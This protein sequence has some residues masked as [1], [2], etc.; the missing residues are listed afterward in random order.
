MTEGRAP[1]AGARSPLVGR[2]DELSLLAQVC[3]RAIEGRRCQ[4]VTIMGDPG[5]GKTRLAEELVARLG[6]EPQVLRGRCLPYGEGITFYPIAEA[7]NQAA[8]LV[9]GA[10]PEEARLKLEALIGPDPDGITDILAEAIGLS[11]ATP[12][13][14]QTLWAI[15]RFFE[16]L[17]ADR[18]LILLFDDLQWGEPTF[19]DLLDS[20]THRA[21][22]VPIVLLCTA[23]PE[24]LERR[25][26]WGGGAMHALTT[27]LEPLSKH[28]SA[29]MAGNLVG[30]GAL[31]PAIAGQLA[32]AGG[33]NPLF[34]QE[35]VAMLLE[36]GSLL[37]DDGGW[38]LTSDPAA[39]ATPP[40]L[41][42]LLA[43]RLD[44]LP[45]DERSVLLHA[46]VIGKVFSVGEVEALVPASLVTSIP[47]RLARL[48]DR[49]LTP[50]RT[51]G[52]TWRRSVR[53]HPPVGSRFRIRDV[54]E[55]HPRRPARAVRRLAGGEPRT[56]GRGI[57]RDRG[58]PP[59]P[60]SPIPARARL[61]RPQARCPR[62]PGGREPEG[63]R[64]AGLGPWRRSGRR[65]SPHSRRRPRTRRTTCAPERDC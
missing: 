60:G 53:V 38:E 33:G 15:R 56:A 52:R 40:T 43:A 4:L 30:G 23:R 12:A 32:E 24:L 35:Y 63:C 49:E 58:L 6:D 42:A 1:V 20:L 55:G 47:D 48:C 2:A 51:N 9:A 18:P 3:H 37:E 7:V 19:L 28:E 5:V 11:G 27:M 57:P 34:L 45:S 39:M 61:T 50:H 26:E 54:A 46:S 31:D 17:A 21:R 8:A 65:T 29:T 10:E 16:I 59:R 44:R 41:A 14:E 22:D 62:R 36:E 25:P 13:P 64:T